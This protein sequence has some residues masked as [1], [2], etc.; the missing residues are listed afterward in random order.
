MR[1]LHLTEDLRRQ[2]AE[3]AALSNEEYKW[4]APGWARRSCFEQK[5]DGLTGW[6]SDLAKNNAT[7]EI[8]RDGIPGI[9]YVYVY[10]YI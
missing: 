9:W 3:L 5:I 7:M 6:N 10:V 8:Y 2:T 4:G 1:I